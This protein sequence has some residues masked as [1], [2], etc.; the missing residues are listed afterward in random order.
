MWRAGRPRRRLLAIVIASSLIFGLLVARIALLQTVDASEYV[1][2]GAEQRSRDTVLPAKRGIIFDRSGD[3]LAISIPAPTIYADPTK[4][5]DKQATATAIG[6]LLGFSPERIAAL[7]DDWTTSTNRFEYVARQID[8]AQADAIM[9]LNLPGIGTYDEQTRVYPAGDV[10]RG[11]LGKTNTEGNGSTGLEVQYEKLLVGTAGKIVRETDQQGRSIPSGT[12]VIEPAVPGSD[13]RLTISRPIQYATEQALLKKVIENGAR[14]GTAIVED[15]DTGEILA[16]AS[17]RR[18]VESGDVFISSANIALVDTYEPGSVAKIITVAAGLNEG[19]VTP[20]TYFEV[21]WRKR[22]YDIDLHDAEQHPTESYSVAKILAKSSNIGTIMISQTIG[23]A[24][25]EAYM[26]SFGLG[27]RTDLG[28][29]GESLGILK[30]ATEWQGTERVTPA[31]GQGVATTAIQLIGAVNT[32]ANGGV[33]VQPKLVYSVIDRQGRETIEEPS[34]SHEVV[35]PEIAGQMNLLMRDVVC[36]GTASKAKVDGFTIAGKT[37]TGYKAQKGGGYIDEN[38]NKSYYAS[39]VGFFP[40]E[41]PEVTVLVS[42]DEPPA[43]GDHYGGSVAAPVFAEIAQ[44]V[45]HELDIRPPSADGG[46]PEN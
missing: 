13:L 14:G 30:P 33:Y 7:A 43:G 39:F 24:K 1:R 20:D 45:I 46:C 9:S 37:G 2:F 21:P 27:S 44:S 26:R 25:Q 22:F 32:L 6:Q 5:V 28:F 23:T 16:M 18:D 17:V 31:Y 3:A 35:R 34:A 8:D 15:V 11:V 10:A 19:T 41:Q 38:G 36:R 40:A 4:V 42:I 29:P 12:R